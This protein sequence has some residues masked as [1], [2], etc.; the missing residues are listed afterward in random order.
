[1]MRATFPIS[2]GFTLVELVTVIVLVGVLSALGIGLFA[3]GSAFSPLLATQQLASA[4][5][6]AQQAALAGN[7]STSVTIRQTSNAFEFE[8]ADSLFSIRREGASVAYQVAGQSGLTAIPGGGFTINF[9]P[10][11][12]LAGPFREKS[13]QFQI[14]GDS[15][16]T[17]CLSS[18]GAVYQGPCS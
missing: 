14:S 9:D 11:G 17:L 6:L 7:P 16:F 10:M 2:S 1:M 3:R 13:L 4:T 12:R 15:D 8:A 18:L 5:L